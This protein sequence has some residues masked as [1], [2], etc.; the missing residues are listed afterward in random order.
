M[1][2]ERNVG[3]S[4]G[5]LFLEQDGVVMFQY[6]MDSASIVGPR[7]ARQ[8]DKDEHKGAWELFNRDRLPQLDHDGNGFPGGSLPQTVLDADGD[9]AFERPLRPVG[10]EHV[11]VDPAP[12]RGRPPKLKD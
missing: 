6:T 2:I 11:H 8:A 5:P 4:A 3:F 1:S 9:V 7:K 10:E 12:R